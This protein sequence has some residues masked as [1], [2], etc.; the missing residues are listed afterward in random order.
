MS[1]TIDMVRSELMRRKDWQHAVELLDSI[2]FLMNGDEVYA[3]NVQRWLSDNPRY[4]TTHLRDLIC[5]PVRHLPHIVAIGK[6][7]NPGTEWDNTW[8]PLDSAIVWAR[9]A[10]LEKHWAMEAAKAEAAMTSL[11]TFGM[12]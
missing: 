10:H 3:E 1:V 7:F 2:E 5:G 11:P 9:E 8:M 6:Q 4:S 12:F